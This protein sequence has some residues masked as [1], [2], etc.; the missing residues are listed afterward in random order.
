MKINQI[1]LINLKL[2]KETCLNISGLTILTGM[3]GMGKSSVIQ[4]M[5]LLRQSFL[6]ND[7]DSGLNLKGDLCDVGTAGEL[8]CQSSP[9]RNFKINLSYSNDSNLKFSFEYPKNEHDTFLNGDEMNITDRAILASYSIFNENFQYLGAFRFGPQKSY[10]R[11]TSLVNTKRQLSKSMGQC[12]YVVHFLDYYKNEPI[13]IKELAIKKDEMYESDYT[14]SSQ[15][16]MWL[17]EIAPNITI[18][19]EP[20]K[21]EFRLKYKFHREGNIITNDI[22][23]I[24]TGF[25]ITYVLPILVSIL[26]AREGALIMIENPEAHIHPAGQATLM[27]LIALAIKGGVQVIIETHS[28]HIINGGLVSIKNRCITKDD[29]AIYYFDRDESEHT[30]ICTELEVTNTGKI[31]KSPKGFF[32]QIGI[33]LKLLTGF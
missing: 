20:S 19:I 29:L 3:N 32:D 13:P 6:M 5:L 12:E 24:N 25:G 16:Q 33:D 31:R 10:D 15:V 8:S 28:D 14:L 2:H 27:K 30:A 9:E 21:E 11:D 17:R 4:S 22:P 18:N 7:L 1:E 26:S 23:A